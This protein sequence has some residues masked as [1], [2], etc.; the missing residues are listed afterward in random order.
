MSVASNVKTPSLV[1]LGVE[2]RRVPNYEG[3]NWYYYLKGKGDVD[4]RA[5]MFDG[6]GHALDGVE[7][8]KMGFEALGKFLIEFIGEREDGSETE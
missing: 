8:E 4:V 2:D 6:N 7:A 3:L 1:M 5:M